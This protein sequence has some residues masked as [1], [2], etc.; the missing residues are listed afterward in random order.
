MPILL[1]LLLLSFLLSPSAA[2]AGPAVAFVGAL[3]SSVAGAAGL[4]GVGAFLGGTWIGQTLV[5]VGL[6]YALGAIGKALAPKQQSSDPGDIQANYAQATSYFER[7]YGRARKGGPIGFTGFADKA[8]HYAVVIAAH[9][10][11]GPFKHYLD[12]VEVEIDAEGEVITDPIDGHGSIR[13]YRGLPGQ[14]ADPVLFEKFSGMTSAHD[15]EGLSYG[16]ITARRPDQEDFSEVY[17]QSREWAYTPVWD[18]YDRIYDPRDGERKWTRNAALIIADWIVECLGGEVDWSDVAVEADVSDQLVQDRTGAWYPRWQIDGVLNESQ[19]VETQRA[20]L[21]IA[22]DAFFYERA[23]GKI[24][25]RVGRYTAPTVELTDT[26]FLSLTLSEGSWGDQSPS[27]IVVQYVEPGHDW[28]QVPSAAWVIDDAGDV[29][30]RTEKTATMV[31]WHNQAMRI[32]KRLARIERARYKLAGTLRL[33]GYEL[34]GKRFFRVRHAE[35]GLNQ[36]FEIDTLRRLED[37][38][39]FEVEAH[40]VAAE[41]F[42]FTPAEEPAPPEYNDAD[43]EDELDA[44]DGIAAVVLSGFSTPA[45][46]VSWSMQSGSLTQLIRYRETSTTVWSVRAIPTKQTRYLITDLRDGATIQIQVANR[47]LAGKLSP[48]G[49][50]DPLEIEATLNSDAPAALRSFVTAD[51]GGGVVEI[52]AR[53]ASSNRNFD[54]VRIR[55]A[56]YPTGYS[57]TASINDSELIATLYGAPGGSLDTEDS[58]GAGHHVYYGQPINASGVPGPVSSDAIDL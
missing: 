51:T 44:P 7:L 33:S 22:C 58:P 43:E 48:Y 6:S 16:A 53:V 26:D 14:D 8:R 42:A 20:M 54:A 3:V 38:I 9:R 46:Q 49:P 36:V 39:S 55:R 10:T 24:G 1:L 52:T 47:T 15:F 41:D 50:E 28:Q 19:D 25:F 17:P 5:S 40:S 4:A 12:E 21:A 18:G 27:E 13:T 56:S 35:L 34:M 2:N 11:K 29:A 23:D 57:G 31:S 30:R 37:G 45:I 32:A